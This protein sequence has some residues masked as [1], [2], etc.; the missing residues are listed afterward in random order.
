MF[1]AAATRPEVRRRRGAIE[2][3]AGRHADAGLQVG[4]GWDGHSERVRRVSLISQ[5]GGQKRFDGRRA[6]PGQEPARTVS[7]KG[8]PTAEVRAS[9]SARASSGVSSTTSRPPP[10]SGTRITM[11][12]PSLVT[13]SGPSP[14]RG[15]IAAIQLP[16]HADQQHTIAAAASPSADWCLALPQPATSHTSQSVP[17]LS[18][19]LPSDGNDQYSRPS[20]SD[21]RRDWDRPPPVLGWETLRFREGNAL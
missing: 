4:A 13:S 10:S 16:F 1:F 5:Q 21:I 14:V 20:R 7:G 15:F 18:S 6:E 8:Q 3:A 19:V 17:L 9:L 12:R 11:P 2:R